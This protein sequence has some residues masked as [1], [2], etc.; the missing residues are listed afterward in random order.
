MENYL[1]EFI[2]NEKMSTEEAIKILDNMASDRIKFFDLVFEYLNE[3]EIRNRCKDI[4]A[5]G[6]AV[7][8][9]TAMST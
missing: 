5:L 7:G 8:V 6:M 9:L 1:E 3:N 2:T 4:M